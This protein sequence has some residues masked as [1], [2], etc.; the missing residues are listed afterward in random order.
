MKRSTHP[1]QSTSSSDTSFNVPTISTPN[2]VL[3]YHKPYI[4]NFIQHLFKMNMSHDA[5]V[6]IIIN[7]DGLDN[8][9]IIIGRPKLLGSSTK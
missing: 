7:D 8:E 5:L 1:I 4:Y 6:D 2:K 3:K 9:T